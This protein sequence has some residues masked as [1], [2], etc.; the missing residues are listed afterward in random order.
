[1]NEVL[2][3]KQ[4]AVFD[5]I[6]AVVYLLIGDPSRITYKNREI[7]NLLSRVQNLKFLQ[8]Y[9]TRLEITQIE[10]VKELKLIQVELFSLF[11]F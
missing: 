5:K 4:Y 7:I 1:M 11:L 6:S 2:F 8:A 10:K 3:V 9:K